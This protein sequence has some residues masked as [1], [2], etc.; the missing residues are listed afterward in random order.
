MLRSQSSPIWAP[1]GIMVAAV[2]IFGC[3]VFPG[4]FSGNVASNLWYF[5]KQRLRSCLPASI[6]LGLFSLVESLS[7]AWLLKHPLC[8]KNGCFRW[9]VRLYYLFIYTFLPSIFFCVGIFLL[10]KHPWGK[11]RAYR[12]YFPFSRSWIFIYLLCPNNVS[13]FLLLV[14]YFWNEQEKIIMSSSYFTSFISIYLCLNNVSALRLSSPYLQW[15]EFLCLWSFSIMSKQSA[16]LPLICHLF[17]TC[18][19]FL[20]KMHPF[21]LVIFVPSI[22]PL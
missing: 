11:K 18:F 2:L 12:I 15:T 10:L 1:S 20:N 9:Q 6:A 4:I 13:H 17:K 3:K 22:L 16:S 7:C 5:Q 21:F 19:F 14:T 8:Y